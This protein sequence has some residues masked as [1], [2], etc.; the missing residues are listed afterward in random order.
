VYKHP[1]LELCRPM[2]GQLHPGTSYF[3]CCWHHCLA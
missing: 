3:P 2:G 1:D